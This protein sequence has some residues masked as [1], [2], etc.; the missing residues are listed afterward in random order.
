MNLLEDRVLVRHTTVAL[1]MVASICC[2]LV[3][4]FTTKSADERERIRARTTLETIHQLQQSYYRDHGTYLSSDRGNTSDVLRW[5]D[6]PG[7]FEYV[8][9]DHGDTYVALAE[10]DLDGDGELEIWRVDPR[11]PDPVLVQSD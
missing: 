8:V 3:F 5:D 10:A 9:L 7:L 4:R 2:M 11:H 1:V 6:M